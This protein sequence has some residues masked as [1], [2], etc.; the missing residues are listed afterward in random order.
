MKE[1]TNYSQGFHYATQVIRI[2]GI[3]YR[4]EGVHTL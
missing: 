4:K 1:T 3:G 2:S